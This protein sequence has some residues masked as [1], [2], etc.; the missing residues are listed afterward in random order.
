LLF[1]APH[2]VANSGGEHF[3]RRPLRAVQAEGFV[4]ETSQR[5]KLG[6]IERVLARKPVETTSSVNS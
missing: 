2:N 4:V 1:A 6:I 3:R 5:S